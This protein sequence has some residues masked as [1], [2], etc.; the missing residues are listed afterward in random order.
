MRVISHIIWNNNPGFEYDH[1]SLD[2]DVVILKLGAPLDLN[3]NVKPAC[4][5]PSADYLDMSS[6]EERC[7]TSGWGTL[8]QGKFIKTLKRKIL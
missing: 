3:D 8:Q 2:N 6:T 5:P 7:F 1:I 4:L